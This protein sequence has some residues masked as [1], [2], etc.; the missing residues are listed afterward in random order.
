MSDSDE[1][2]AELRTKALE[3]LRTLKKELDRSEEIHGYEAKGVAH[4]G[5]P[6]WHE[7]YNDALRDLQRAGEDIR[8]SE[9]RPPVMHRF[10]ASKR[11]PVEDWINASAL[12]H[13]I[14]RVL[15]RVAPPDQE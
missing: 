10:R 8:D 3:S 9:I 2:R 6:L 7:I 5:I 13:S 4:M 12:R 11:A 15:E 1:V 14:K